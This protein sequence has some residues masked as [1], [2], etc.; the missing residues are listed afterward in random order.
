MRDERRGTALHT[1]A[2]HGNVPGARLLLAAFAAADAREGSGA[3]RGK[4]PLLELRDR[5]H[6]TACHW[7]VVN[8]QHAILE[9]LV[10]AGASVNGVSMPSR[11]HTRATCAFGERPRAHC[12]T[13]L[14]LTRD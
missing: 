13:R 9:M 8:Q 4:E 1:A 7:A 6:R 14:R 10:Q 2:R 5:W 11:K 12:A 3:S